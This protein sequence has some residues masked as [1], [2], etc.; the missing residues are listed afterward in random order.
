MT[1]R[2]W[3]RAG[4]EEIESRSSSWL[5]RRPWARFEFHAL[6]TRGAAIL[7]VGPIVVFICS[8][9]F[10]APHRFL[11]LSPSI[12][13][14]FLCAFA[15]LSTWAQRL[16]RNGNPQRLD[17]R[18]SVARRGVLGCG[19]GI[20]ER[21]AFGPKPN[22][23]WRQRGKQRRGEICCR[24]LRCLSRRSCYNRLI[25]PSA[26]PVTAHFVLHLCKGSAW[27]GGQLISVMRRKAGSAEPHGQ[28]AKPRW[29]QWETFNLPL[30]LF[31]AIKALPRQHGPR[32]PLRPRHISGRRS[33]RLS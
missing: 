25:L 8:C 21:T 28:W 7:D 14:G 23:G 1:F 2:R 12:A 31:V 3:R 15:V 32:R 20:V 29:L 22:R 10:V 4:S 17:P 6:A 19:L 26:T 16:V 5:L 13:V 11:R 27:C 30:G 33:E 18:C 9:L 24:Q